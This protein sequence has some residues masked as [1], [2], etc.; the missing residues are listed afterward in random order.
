VQD[1][2]S[3]IYNPGD[4][5]R[6]D[7]QI[8]LFVYRRAATSIPEPGSRD[9][10]L[11]RRVSPSW[12]DSPLP[13]AMCRRYRKRLTERLIRLTEMSDAAYRTLQYVVGAAGLSRPQMPADMHMHWQPTR[14]RKIQARLGITADE[15][16]VILE[17]RRKRAVARVIS[18]PSCAP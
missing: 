18:P 4:F 15:M 5:V 12:R 2:K 11:W 6:H 8:W 17:K 16:S 3:G 13:D 1:W 7:G 10:R 14:L 9:D